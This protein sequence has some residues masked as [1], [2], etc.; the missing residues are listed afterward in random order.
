MTTSSAP[1]TSLGAVADRDLGAGALEGRAQRAQVAGAVVDHRRDHR[2]PFVLAMPLRA[3]SG[4]TASRSAS[5]TALKAASADV[6]RV[7]A[8]SR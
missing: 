3:A 1:A 4:S 2:T 8:A 7:L 6:V 5:A